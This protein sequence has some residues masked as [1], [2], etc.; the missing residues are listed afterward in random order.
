[1]QIPEDEPSDGLSEIEITEEERER[2]IKEFDALA[3][4]QPPPMEAWQLEILKR[5][6]EIEV[7]RIAK[8]AKDVDFLKDKRPA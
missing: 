2:R 6:K 7:E 1:M 5:D 4:T 3:A 8:G